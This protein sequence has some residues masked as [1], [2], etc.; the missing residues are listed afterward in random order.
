MS[1]TIIIHLLLETHGEHCLKRDI[2]TP[3]Y[4]LL[5][6]KILGLQLVC[7]VSYF[8][9]GLSQFN[10]FIDNQLNYNVFSLKFYYENFQMYKDERIIY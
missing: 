4:S 7:L 9:E 6:I 10:I 8:F 5:H 1:Y 3:F 2:L